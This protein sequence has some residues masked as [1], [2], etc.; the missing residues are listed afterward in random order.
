GLG[1]TRAGAFGAFALELVIVG[2]DDTAPVARLARTERVIARDELEARLGRR[3][4]AGAERRLREGERLPGRQHRARDAAA[5]AERLLEGLADARARALLEREAID[6][7]RGAR[8]HRGREL[9]RVD[10]L[11]IDEV[12]RPSLAEQRLD[13]RPVEA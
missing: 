4:L 5:H 8:E 3:G 12:A 9:V 13:A 6:E 2:G 11:A 1:E 10:D 7:R